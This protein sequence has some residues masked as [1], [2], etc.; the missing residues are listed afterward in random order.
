MRSDVSL[1]LANGHANANFYPIGRVWYE[2]QIIRERVNGM[3]ATEAT[4][5]HSVISAVI[6]PKKD[7]G[8][9]TFL[10]RLLMRLRNG[11]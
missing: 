10:R 11:G 5:M 7:S 9:R 3:L 4:L 2:C 8:A 6:S 1:L